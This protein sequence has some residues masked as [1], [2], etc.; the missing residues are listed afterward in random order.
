MK[1]S[2]GDRPVLGAF[3]DESADE[4]R[5]GVYAVGVFLA[6]EAYSRV[7]EHA[8][9]KRLSEDAVPYFR[10]TDC[11]AVVG[12]FRSLRQKYGGLENAREAAARIR[13]DLEEI[14]LSFHWIGLGIGVVVEDYDVVLKEIPETG[15]FFAKDHTIAAY[16]QIIYEIARAI[17]KKAPGHAVSFMIDGSSSREKIQDA[18]RAIKIIHPVVGSSITTITAGDDKTVVSLQVADLLASIVKDSFLKWL[19]A[20]RLQHVPLEA[21]WVDHFEVIGTWDAAQMLRTFGKTLRSPRFAKGLLP[22]PKQPPIRK[23]V[24][25][26]ARREMVRQAMRDRRPADAPAKA[27]EGKA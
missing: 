23:S 2:T 6:S 10:S 14:L 5:T 25:K 12:P 21:K 18:V 24:I 1:S 7:I 8:W 26:K 17:R 16:S 27:P 15:F 19:A 11:R 13:A 4:T 9:S 20:G 22:S 3:L